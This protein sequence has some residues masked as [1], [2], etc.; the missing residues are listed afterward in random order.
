MNDIY[1]NFSHRLR[2]SVKWS[3]FFMLLSGGAHAVA[4]ESCREA[5][6]NENYQQAESVCL[7]AAEAG[8]PEAQYLVAKGYFTGFFGGE[9]LDKAIA[10]ARACQQTRPGDCLNVLGLAFRDKAIPA[11]LR[12][13]TDFGRSDVA[14][15]M[16]RGFVRMQTNADLLVQANDALSKAASHGSPKAM[17]NIGDQYLSGAWYDFEAD[18]KKAMDWGRRASAAGFVLGDVLQA[19]AIIFDQLSD[20]YPDLSGL[21]VPAVSE[22]PEASFL[23]ARVYERG[24]AVPKDKI[25][26]YAWMTLALVRGYQHAAHSL[27]VADQHLSLS[28]ME[29]GKALAGDYFE[30]YVK[31]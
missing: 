13:R 6:D 5:F 28:E 22:V 10:Y 18:P 11:S 2:T 9:D 24:L 20:N 29:K 26:A 17:Y 14:I 8:D 21:L 3:V 15:E 19:R 30:R 7:A 27:R 4:G 12:R 31:N 16:F 23:L 1:G 25:R